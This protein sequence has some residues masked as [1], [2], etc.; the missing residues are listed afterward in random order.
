MHR[1]L[2]ANK[3]LLGN[4]G[5]T[6]T[7]AGT[8]SW[9]ER[10][11][12]LPT[13]AYNA[14]FTLMGRKNLY[15]FLKK[16]RANLNSG[17][18]TNGTLVY[19]L[20]NG[21]RF[22]LHRGNHLSELVYLE[23][24]YEPLETIIV[25]QLIEPGDFVLDLGA[26]VGYFTALLDQLVGSGGQVHSFEPGEGTFAKLQDT[27]R[28]LGLTQSSL[29][30]KA[31]GETNG[32]IDFWSSTSGSDAQQNTVSNPVLGSHL[33]LTKVQS[34]TLDDFLADLPNRRAEKIAFVKCD[35]EGAEPAMLK[36]AKSLLQSHNPPIWLMEH[37]RPALLDHGTNSA[38]LLAHF[39]D[40]EIYFVPL[41]W[42]P[43]IMASPQAEKWSGIPNDLPDE[44]N[45]LIFPKRGVYAARVSKLRR[46]GLL[47]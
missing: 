21:N 1:S 29:Y 9:R 5:A 41:C 4:P 27:K 31:V 46:N 37:N 40:F 15:Y 6:R 28:I 34:A 47:A 8:G 32:L 10:L 13:K 30:Q 38:D 7:Y 23:G 22:V 3:T 39:I 20:N 25:S 42:P 36:A 33:R 24:A 11:L 43:S 19:S 2:N 45:L 44:C 18:R 12:A 14:L 17:Y 35:I 26:N 16:Y